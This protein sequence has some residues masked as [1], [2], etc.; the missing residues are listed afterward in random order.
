V[1]GLAACALVAA[2]ALSAQPALASSRAQ[3]RVGGVPRAGPGSTS[4]GALAGD[5][6]LG[7]T[8]T[9]EPRDPAALAGYASAVA[10][11]GAGVYHDYITPAQF[12]QR[13]GPTGAQIAAVESSLRAHG[14]NPEAVSANGLAIP[15]SATA[16]ELSA[17]FSTSFQRVVVPGGRTAYANTSAPAVDASVARVVQSVVGLDTLSVPQPLAL[18]TSAHGA[19]RAAAPHVA[20]GGPQ[21]CAAATAA[22]PGDKAQTADQLASAYDFSGF[23][24]AGDFG[25]GQTVAIYELEGNFH[26]DINAF[27]KC[28]GTSTSV[29]Y[30]KVDHGPPAPNAGSFDGLESELDIEDLIGLAPEASLIVY[31][32]PNLGLGGPGS[33]PYDTY[34]AIISE[35]FAKVIT[36]SWGLCESTLGSANAQAE[37]TLFQEAATQGQ[38]II[39]ASGDA[40]SEDCYNAVTNPGATG[41]AVDDPSSQPFVT[42]AGGTTLTALGPPPS[43]VAWNDSCCGAGGGGI[44]TLWPMPSY[45]S[46]A[47]A[48]LGVIGPDS[49]GTPCAAPS[50]GDCRQ[51][52]DV[53]ADAGDTSGYQIYWNGHWA[54][55]FGT[56]GAA[57][58]WA[59]M[60]ALT[61]ATKGCGGSPVGFANPVLY[62]AAA[63]SAYANVFNDITSGNNDYLGAH[64]GLFGAR[65]GYDMA[66]GLGTPIGA[67][68]AGAVCDKVTVGNP[69]P[70]TSAVGDAV[71]LPLPAI[72]TS[73]G[74]LHYVATGLPSGL[75][76]NGSTGV[77]SGAPTTVGSWNVMVLATAADGVVGTAT[78]T[79]TVIAGPPPITAPVNVAITSPGDQTGMV[80]KPVSLPVSASDSNGGALSYGASGLPAGLAINGSTGLISGTPTVAG[81]SA[82]TVT[83]SEPG[84]ASA[85]A[86]FGWTVDPVRVAVTSP[87]NQSGIVGKPVSLQIHA[88]SNN[89]ARLSDRASGLPRGLA[90]NASSGVISGTP[91]TVGRSTVTVATVGSGGVQSTASFRWTIAAAATVS[92]TTISGVA[93]RRAKLSFTV[94][95][96]AGAA[97]IKTIV[98]GLPTGLRFSTNPGRLLNGIVVKAPAG[99]RLRFTAKLDHG[100]L[101]ITL[102]A[103]A[104]R[105]AVA[106]SGDAL[107]VT[108]RL[109]QQAARTVT[110]VSV[111]I[112][113]TN[114]SHASTRVAPRIRVG[115]RS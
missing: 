2:F 15:V 111:T 35:D 106:I 102:T 91:T 32:G 47:P 23:Y 9:L 74:S 95:A 109:A 83:A 66:T 5:A 22:A 17:A 57:P 88:T 38:S 75:L 31:Q 41:L 48:S 79:W 44:S 26:A 112:T 53:S 8:V 61:N 34:S 72:S 84:A 77:V 70:Q 27:Q 65:V 19:A 33:G 14:L 87:G 92:H 11:P 30:T 107:A 3:I 100:P 46:D 39:A 78:F 25:T 82:V 86:S 4:V 42:G 81:S 43:E 10:T 64:R 103:A 68:L 1:L 59:S 51:I 12:A 99:K 16:A 108:K 114:S 93:R 6:R 85:K 28:Y 56:S 115:P 89:G 97:P 36:T 37:N 55:V 58:T 94:A 7:V 45:Q 67:T 105:P 113:V 50:R 101:T 29:T 54:G 52:P 69:G 60:I 63:S 13:F 62:R 24:G 49:S 90:I 20:T 40:G 104:P 98:I 76:I 110:S 96:T 21:P 80:G 71:K 73:G 18:R